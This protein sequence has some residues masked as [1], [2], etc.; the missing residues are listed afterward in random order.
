MKSTYFTFILVLLFSVAF[1]QTKP[2][3]HN[4]KTKV[5]KTLFDLNKTDTIR[6]YNLNLLGKTAWKNSLDADKINL[7]PRNFDWYSDMKMIE[8]YKSMAFNSRQQ[9]GKGRDFPIDVHSDVV[10]NVYSKSLLD[11]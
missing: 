2:T 11:R 8:S 6:V 5:F 7:L 3:N 9:D 1:G 4:F 10:K